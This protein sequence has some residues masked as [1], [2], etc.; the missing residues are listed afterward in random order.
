MVQINNVNSITVP[1]VTILMENVSFILSAPHGH[2]TPAIAG[3]PVPGLVPGKVGYALLLEGAELNYGRPTSECFYDVT[4]CTNGLSVSLW[5]KFN[6]ASTENQMILD[7]GG[8]YQETK[9]MSVF[10]SSGAGVMSASIFDNNNAYRGW[11]PYEDLFHWQH[12]VFTWKSPVGIL[13]YLN[14]CPSGTQPDVRPR[15]PVSADVDFRIGGNAWG[16]ASERGNIA[17][18]HVLMWYGMLTPEEV[19]QIYS[20][21]KL[22]IFY[23]T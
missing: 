12:I 18:D 2:L 9:G 14:G 19:W 15:S 16:G 3:A 23:S 17:L 8:F 22:K 5:V 1:D 4:L 11:A 20:N 13:L 7:G 6:A 21:S 10:R